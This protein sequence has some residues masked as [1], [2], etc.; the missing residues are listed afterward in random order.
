MSNIYSVSTQAVDKPVVW[1]HT[2]K[3]LLVY[4]ILMEIQKPPRRVVFDIGMEKYSLRFF[5]MKN[6]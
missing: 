1:A 6:I 5:P 4:F 3:N 2:I